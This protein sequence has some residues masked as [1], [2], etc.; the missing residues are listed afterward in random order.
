MPS[1]L[2]RLIQGA[3]IV[4]FAL[5]LAGLFAWL[6]LMGVDWRN[7]RIERRDFALCEARIQAAGVRHDFPAITRYCDPIFRASGPTGDMKG[8]CSARLQEWT[9]CYDDASGT[10]PACL[11]RILD[12]CRTAF[13]PVFW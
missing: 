6:V 12:G 10:M 4:C 3:A 5:F 7:A 8:E 2:L 1:R 13:P 9:G 11:V